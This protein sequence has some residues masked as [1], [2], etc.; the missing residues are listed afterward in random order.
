MPFAKKLAHLEHKKICVFTRK[1]ELL[2]RSPAWTGERYKNDPHIHGFEYLE[3]I[4]P[5]DIPRILRWF[6]DGAESCLEFNA[7]L[8]KSGAMARIAYCKI[9]YGE[10]WLIIG[11]VV[12]VKTRKPA[13]KFAA[14][15]P[16]D[17]V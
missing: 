13:Q 11:N 1:G 15:D 5:R 2:W 8:P 12:E 3:F 16:P 14:S 10:N 9:P 6:T 4:A 7:L 17:P